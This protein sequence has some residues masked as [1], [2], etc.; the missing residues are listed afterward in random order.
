MPNSTMTNRHSMVPKAHISRSS[1]DRSSTYKTAFD[2]SYLVP[3]RADS[4]ILPGDTVNLSVDFFIRMTTPIV[5][6]MDLS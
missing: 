2:A 1:F 5:P 4:D 3:F 6:S